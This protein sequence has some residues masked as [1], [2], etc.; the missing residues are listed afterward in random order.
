VYGHKN[1]T[2]LYHPAMDTKE[3]ELLRPNHAG[4]LVLDDGNTINYGVIDIVAD[5]LRY[6]TGKGLRDIWAPKMSEG[7]KARAEALKGK[8]IEQLIAEDYAAEVPLDRIRRVLF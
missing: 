5:R 4:A 3:R 2:T 1:S 6:Y 7:Q 8:T